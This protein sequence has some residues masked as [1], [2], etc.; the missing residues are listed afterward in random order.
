MPTPK[1]STPAS[2]R[3][4][5][6]RIDIP[7]TPEEQAQLRGLAAAWGCSRAE[8]MRRALVEAHRREVGG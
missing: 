6:P 5:L 4:E 2:S 8:A 1:P 3:R 7:L